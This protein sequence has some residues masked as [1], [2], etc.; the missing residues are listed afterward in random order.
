MKYVSH[1][2]ERAC[3]EQGGGSWTMRFDGWEWHRNGEAGSPSSKRGWRAEV[4]IKVIHHER[5][6]TC[7]CLQLG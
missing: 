1:A 4:K 2:W 7:G 5:S 6:D 3:F